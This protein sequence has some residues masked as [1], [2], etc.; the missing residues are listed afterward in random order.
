MLKITVGDWSF[1]G[2]EGDRCVQEPESW[3]FSVSDGLA[4]KDRKKHCAWQV[5]SMKGQSFLT[6]LSSN[7]SDKKEAGGEKQ[8]EG[9][10]EA[11]ISSHGDGCTACF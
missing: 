6:N 8:R 9:D 3:Q 5:M 10:V 7:R 11:G 4:N 1:P 2:E